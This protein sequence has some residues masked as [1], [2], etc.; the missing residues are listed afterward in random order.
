[1]KD[2]LIPAFVLVATLVW[3]RKCIGISS[4]EASLKLTPQSASPEK[5]TFTLFI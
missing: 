1:M 3:T 5:I 4:K 2:Y